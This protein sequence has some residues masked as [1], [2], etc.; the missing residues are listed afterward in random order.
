MG[1]LNL[2]ELQLVL[3]VFE[4]A[5]VGET[6]QCSTFFLPSRGRKHRTVQDWCIY[7]RAF[8][9]GVMKGSIIITPKLQRCVAGGLAPHG[10]NC[11]HKPK[12]FSK[13]I[14]K[15][16]PFQQ[17]FSGKE[18]IF[19]YIFRGL[20]ERYCWEILSLLFLDGR[21]PPK[22]HN[23]RSWSGWVLKPAAQEMLE[24]MSVAQLQLG[25]EVLKRFFF[26]R[27]LPMFHHFFPNRGRKHR[28]VQDWCRYIHAFDV[29]V[30]KG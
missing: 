26:W 29:G 18:F 19:L 22:V 6:S 10:P 20:F 5:F 15:E 21:R 7:I 28:T 23:P 4:T 9:V 1:G 11:S 12:K 3:G 14:W 2:A 16:P 30:T 27:N 25:S 24:G 13:G 17:D 8:D